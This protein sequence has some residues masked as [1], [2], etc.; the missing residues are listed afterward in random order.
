M[1]RLIN[2]DFLN[3][4]GFKVNLSNKAKLLYFLYLANADDKGFV[5]NAKE[6]A[7]TLDRCEENFDNV[8]FNLKYLDAAQ[9][10]VDKRLVFDFTDK[11]GNHTY[12]IRHWFIHNKYRPNLHTNFVSYLAKVDLIDGK[13][14]YKG[15]NE[16][17]Y[18]GKQNKIEQNNIKQNNVNN[19][20]SS[21]NE[22]NNDD[23]NWEKQ[24][25]YFID[26]I[27]NFGGGKDD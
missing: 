19:N 20:I 12:L 11:V 26:D 23:S 13:Y 3:A 21:L 24:W 18:K 1:F 25:D 14:Q 2:C 27:K 16:N 17:P 5:G 7:E 4:S 8:L 9:E 6:I 22:D 10:L 15:S